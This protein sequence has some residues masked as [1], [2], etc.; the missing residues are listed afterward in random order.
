MKKCLMCQVVLIETISLR[1]IIFFTKLQQESLCKDCRKK[2]NPL[3][4]KIVCKGCGRIRFETS[5]CGDCLNWKK[6]DPTV[7]LNHK[8]LFE[9]ND[10]MKEWIESF[11]FKG[12]YQLGCV[13]SEELKK[14]LQLKKQAGFLVVPIPISQHSYANRGFNQVEVLLDFAKVSYQQILLNESQEMKQSSKN[15]YERLMLKQPF[16]IKKDWQEQLAG[17]SILLVDDVY[18]TGRTILYAKKLIEDS[19]ASLVQS[20]SLAR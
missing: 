8:S 1:K 16:S 10:W 12:N 9:Y 19:G 17:K 6:T 13:F 20:V 14:I 2:F 18:T 11:K 7:T 5:Y 15:R 4:K 3:A